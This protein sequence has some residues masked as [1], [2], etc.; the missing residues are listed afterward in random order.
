MVEVEQLLQ[1]YLEYLFSTLRLSSTSPF[2]FFLEL[3]G[4]KDVSTTMIDTHVVN[5]DGRGIHNTADRLGS[6]PER[7]E[8]QTE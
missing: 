5:R 2:S 1:L 3:L 4:H 8:Q 6:A 7:H